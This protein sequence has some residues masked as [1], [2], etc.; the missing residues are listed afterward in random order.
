MRREIRDALAPVLRV[1]VQGGE[2][3]V[4]KDISVQM[5]DSYQ[6]VLLTVRPIGRW[7]ERDGMLFIITFQD[8]EE[9]GRELLAKEEVIHTSSDGISA[10]DLRQ[11]V[12]RARLHLRHTIEDM[13]ASQEEPRA[14]M[15]SFSST[16]EELTTSKEELQSLNEELITVNAEHQ[17]KIEDLSQ[18]NDDLQNLL[19]STEIAILFL[20]N[21]LR[22]R[23]F[24]DPIRAIVNLQAGDMGRPIIDLAIR[25][26]DGHLPSELR[27]VLRTL[28]MRVR[29][30]QA[31]D[32]RWL[33]MRIRPYRTV[34]NRIDGLMVI[35]VDISLIKELDAAMQEAYA[36]A[37]AVVATAHEPLAVLDADLRVI[38]T[39]HS[40][41]D[42]LG[43]RAR[44]GGR[45]SF[46]HISGFRRLFERILSENLEA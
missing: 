26:R 3:L 46:M 16:N 30:V 28:Q 13:Q 21:D 37:E 10:G 25:L 5:E 22:I 2:S 27:A 7:T 14:R 29:E 41:S 40:F 23:R 18:I 8:G 45:E 32:G 38:S 20:D 43:Y 44:G 17:R 9:Q 39:N 1:A 31:T 12:A 35:F 24:T 33:E 11:E 34:E 36:Y 42:I 15:R 6:Q 4:Q 19:Q